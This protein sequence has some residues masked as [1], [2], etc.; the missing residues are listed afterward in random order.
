[1]EENSLRKNRKLSTFDKAAMTKNELKIYHK[2]RANIRWVITIVIWS[3]LLSATLSY[4]SSRAMMQV[5]IIGA[6]AIL[7]IFIFLGILFDIIGISV[8][9]AEE[10]PFHSMAARKLPGARESI[11]LLRNAEKVSNFCNDVVGDICNIISGS[12]GAVL[13]AFIAVDSRELIT[14]LV[15][16]ALIASITIGGKAIGK[17][18]AINNANWIVFLVGRLVSFFDFR[19]DNRTR[20]KKFRDPS[21]KRSR[22]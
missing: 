13:V 17:G 11:K 1:L 7:A 3:F 16:T 14:S 18:I 9:S 2:R 10:R 15:V 12:A 21:N 5:G 6:C 4:I 8:T 19:P 20:L 22:K